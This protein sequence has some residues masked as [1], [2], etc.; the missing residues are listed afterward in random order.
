MGAL[1]RMREELQQTRQALQS[2]TQAL[3]AKSEEL[4]SSLEEIGSANEEIQ[5]TNEEL[6]TSKEELESMNE[7]LNTL[8]SQ[9][10][11]QNQELTHANNA[12]YNFLQST[13]VGIIFLDQNLEIREYTQAVTTIFGLRKSDIGRPLAEI[14]S[15]V[16]LRW[17]D[18]RCCPCAGHARQRRSG[19]RDC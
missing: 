14:H 16:G 8:N 2:A 6:R 4:T 18:R 11:N 17:A 9:L 3:Q 5:T 19:D 13:A 10:T 1:T 15:Q 12:L 7:E